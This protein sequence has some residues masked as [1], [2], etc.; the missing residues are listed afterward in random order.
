MRLRIE[1][2]TRAALL[3]HKTIRCLYRVPLTGLKTRR[4]APAIA[5]GQRLVDEFCEHLK[6]AMANSA[7]GGGSLAP[8]DGPDQTTDQ[9]TD[10]TPG[11]E[12][13]SYL[14][15]VYLASYRMALLLFDVFLPDIDD[16]VRRYMEDSTDIPVHFAF[17]QSSDGTLHLQ[18]RKKLDEKAIGNYYNCLFL[19]RT[20]PPYIMDGLFPHSYMNG[21]RQERDDI[22]GDNPLQKGR[23][24]RLPPSMQARNERRRA[25]ERAA[26]QAE[27]GENARR[28]QEELQCDMRREVSGMTDEE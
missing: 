20:S 4:E 28:G 27:Q 13:T 3:A 14:H 15:I 17:R 10:P 2:T 16:E 22:H 25:I 26:E 24:N 21:I 18:R 7:P 6:K 11:P 1:E 9:S 19:D 12:I 5:W 8:V 23:P